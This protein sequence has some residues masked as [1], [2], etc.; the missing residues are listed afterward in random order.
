M[1]EHAEAESAEFSPSFA[2][3][4]RWRDWAAPAG[5]KGNDGGQFFTPR[6]VIRAVMRA[7]DP[8]AGE[9]VYDL[10]CGTPAGMSRQ[11]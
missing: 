1:A 7:V 3:P 11:C 6:E 8:K 4:C 5:E 9:T 2:A 10:G